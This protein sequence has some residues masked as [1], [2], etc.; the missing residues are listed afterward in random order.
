MELYDVYVF[1]QRYANPPVGNL[2]W[3]PPI[4][5]H[6]SQIQNA[7]SLGPACIQQIPFEKQTLIEKIYN[8]PAPPENEDCL[9]L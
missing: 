6:S 4:A 3:E 9:F 7:T 8:T 1:C 2:R 5:F